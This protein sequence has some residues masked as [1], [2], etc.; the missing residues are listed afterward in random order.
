MCPGNRGIFLTLAVDATILDIGFLGRR[1]C[2]ARIESSAD[3]L[4]RFLAEFLWFLLRSCRWHC[5]ILLSPV[6]ALGFADFLKRA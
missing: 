5:L 4:L 2:L 6:Q 3:F 1:R